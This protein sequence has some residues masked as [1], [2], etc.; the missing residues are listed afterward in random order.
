MKSAGNNGDGNNASEFLSLTPEQRGLMTEWIAGEYDTASKAFSA[1]SY[2]E[3]HQFEDSEYGFYVTNG[4]FKG[5]MLEMGWKPID[6]S[7]MNWRY[8][9]KLKRIPRD[10]R[11]A[12]GW[13]A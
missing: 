5:A 4:Q 13:F 12:R 7:E 2:G 6:A 10:E 8:K 1:T 3:K 11:R 9:I